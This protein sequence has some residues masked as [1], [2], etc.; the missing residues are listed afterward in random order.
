MSALPEEPNH[1]LSWLQSNYDNAA[2]PDDFIPRAVFGKYIQSLI[3]GDDRLEHLQTTAV[4]CIV[5]NGF[6]T[7]QFAIGGTIKADAVVLAL[8]NF[9]PPELSGVF[10]H[11]AWNQATYENLPEDAPVALIGSGLT[12]IDVFL[13]LREN[14]H[15]GVIHAI[16]RHGMLPSRHAP[17]QPLPECIIPRHAP[18]TTR[19][20]L[21]L[22][23]K[24]ISDGLP[25]RAVIDSLRP[26]TNEVW[27]GLPIE[28]QRRFK[29]H[30]Q[31]HWDIVRHRM[32][33][34]IAD[35]VDTELAAGTLKVHRG[36]LELIEQIEPARVINCTGPNLNYRKVGSPLLNSLFTQGLSTPGPLGT[37]L[38]TD[39]NGA[40][41]ATNGTYSRVLFHVGPGRQGNLLEAIAVPELR[42]QA[43]A[44]AVFLAGQFDREQYAA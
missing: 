23:R 16:S 15:R 32:A 28:E 21:R 10:C 29:R 7:L 25:W 27:L 43:A 39:G 20:L 17:Y 34:T 12:A 33:P 24:A 22:V 9:N 30:L 42:E 41:K 31:R 19:Q 8:G 14:G 2:T 40:L 38:A 35:S 4:D 5:E 3:A 18:R 13:R 1:F 11:S 6:A 44:L 37:A 26:R 36:S